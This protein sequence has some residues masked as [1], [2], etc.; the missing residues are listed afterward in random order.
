MAELVNL[1]RL[2]DE[3]KKRIVPYLQELFD[4]HNE[5]IVSVF[6]Y[7]SAA[8]KDMLPMRRGSLPR[9]RPCGASGQRPYP[10]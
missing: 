5:N 2:P 9:L 3:V 10:R 7:G 8:G 4:V 1:E 6:V